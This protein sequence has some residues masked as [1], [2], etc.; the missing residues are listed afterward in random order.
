VLLV[1]SLKL[2]PHMVDGFSLSGTFLTFAL[3]LVLFL[4]I[5]FFILPETKAGTENATT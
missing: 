1:V 3:V 4:P 5:I 2:Y